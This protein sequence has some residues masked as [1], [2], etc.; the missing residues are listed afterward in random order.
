MKNRFALFALALLCSVATARSQDASPSPEPVPYTAEQLDE[1]L[2]PIA[3]YPDALVAIM[4]PA[5]ASPTDIVM[6]DRYMQDGGSAEDVDN[7]NWDDSVKS[8]TRYPDVLAWMSKNLDWTEEVGQAFI[9]QPVDVMQS[10]QRLRAAAIAAGQL[11][12]NDK[13]TV[14]VEKE[15]IRIV[16][17]KPEVIYVPVYDPAV[18]YV[19]P[20][21]SPSFRSSISFSVGYPVGYWLYSDFDWG[22]NSIVVI[23]RSYRR[24]AWNDCPDWRYRTVWRE[25]TIVHTWRPSYRHYRVD[26]HRHHSDYSHRR[27]APTRFDDRDFN[28]RSY[29]RENRSE[30]RD[31]YDNRSTVGNDD[32]RR[33]GERNRN[34]DYDRDR[35]REQHTN[36]GS[37]QR[38]STPRPRPNVEPVEVTRSQSTTRTVTR[39]TIPNS[40]R[41]GP[42]QVQSPRQTTPRPAQAVN[43]LP[44]SAKPAYRPQPAQARP[45]VAQPQPASAPVRVQSQPNPPARQSTASVQTS[46]PA[47][48]PQPRASQPT[49]ARVEQPKPGYQP[50]TSNARSQRGNEAPPARSGGSSNNS[51]RGGR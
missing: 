7:K 34:E 43:Q 21:Y 12:S 44:A 16:P 24:S 22:Y 37:T 3:L 9:D 15:V 20:S 2:G 18:V 33:D 13:Q 6:A 32:R 35:R 26:R 36:S 47:P 28:R 46:R 27:S 38:P 11:E 48:T 17:A 49:P 45:Q 29:D 31:R 25:P 30:R 8:L 41:N 4:L 5:A 1:L 51:A 50:P 23:N 42:A 39:A 14:I 19:R 10:A 40:N